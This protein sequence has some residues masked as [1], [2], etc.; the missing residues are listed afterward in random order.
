MRFDSVP[1][2]VN[3]TRSTEGKRLQMSSAN[4]C[5]F[6]VGPPSVSPFFAASAIAAWMAGFE[7]P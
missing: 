4:S 7:C 6:G 1:E 2:F 3:R 5:W